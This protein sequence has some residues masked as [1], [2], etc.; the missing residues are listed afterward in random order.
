[1]RQSAPS[2]RLMS[3]LR[4]SLPGMRRA[5]EFNRTGTADQPF[6]LAC[7]FASRSRERI[8]SQPRAA[9]RLRTST[10]STALRGWRQPARPALL[11]PRW[12]GYRER[13]REPASTARINWLVQFVHASL[14]A[15][16]IWSP[17]CRRTYLRPPTIPLRP[18]STWRKAKNAIEPYSNWPRSPSI[19]V[20]SQVSSVITTAERR[21]F[22]G[23]NPKLGIQTN[24]SAARSGC[25]AR[26]AV[27]CPT[28][29]V[30]WAMS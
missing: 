16:T 19:A 1:M 10:A 17:P 4:G 30:P 8:A 6:T 20:M 7:P 23:A 2:P 25:T 28:S 21:N 9:S 18:W 27:I 3:L 12:L 13:C 14:T 5:G 15:F 22:G 11:N 24:A 26:T 29:S